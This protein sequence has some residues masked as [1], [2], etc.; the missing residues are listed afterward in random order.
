MAKDREGSVNIYGAMQAKTAQG[1]VAYTD[2]IAHENEDGTVINLDVML[3]NGVGGGSAI[4]DVDELPKV[5]WSGTE[6]PNSG[7]CPDIYLNTNL[8]IEEV[9]SVLDKVE[10]TDMGDGLAYF[11]CLA[12]YTTNESSGRSVQINIA[13][14]NGEYLIAVIDDEST[15]VFSTSSM[16][17]FKGWLTGFNGIS[18]FSKY[19]A[20]LTNDFN[21]IPVGSQNSQLSSLFSTTPFVKGEEPKDDVFYRLA[22]STQGGWNGTPVPN[23]G[24]VENIYFN[25]NLTKEQIIELCK[26]LNYVLADGY[27]YFL[28]SNSDVSELFVIVTDSDTDI[29]E[30]A[31]AKLSNE[32]TVF[33]DSSDIM[34]VGITTGWNT[35]ISYPFAVNFDTISEMSG[36]QIGGQNEL[37]SSLFSTTPFEYIEGGKKYDIYSYKDNE[38]KKVLQE[39]DVNTESNNS[40]QKEEINLG[41]LDLTDVQGSQYMT[42]NFDIDSDTYNKLLSGNCI[43]KLTLNFS[44]FSGISGAT[45]TLN[46]T[47]NDVLKGTYSY[48]GNTGS[49]VY[50]STFPI[51]GVNQSYDNSSSSV[52]K[53]EKYNLIPSTDGTNYW[54]TFSRFKF[55]QSTTDTVSQDIDSPVTSKGVYNTLQSY[56][57]TE[58]VNQMIADYITTNFEN[59]NEGEF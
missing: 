15:P 36:F 59:F 19:N 16:F 28:L 54:V 6:V 49:G 31:I 7:I 55:I 32:I 14:M 50:Y 40:N 5:G 42:K 1:I 30:I 37:I 18:N 48:S 26:Q 8:S 10:F 35:E 12:Q 52:S 29:S 22:I 27:N 39:G 20:T 53:A 56:A 24:T 23:S 38:Y 2:G 41:S 34:G 21:G 33:Y 25:T 58:E 9:K 43:P 46:L 3:K 11:V 13:S 57:K 4:V 17:G 51:G 44:N 47:F 45:S